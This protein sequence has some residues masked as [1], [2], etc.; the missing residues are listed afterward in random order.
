MERQRADLSSQIKPVLRITGLARA[1][2]MLAQSS[3]SLILRLE[4]QTQR[5]GLPSPWITLDVVSGEGSILG[6]EWT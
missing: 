5:A 3:V 2:R 1:F 6:Q 4:K